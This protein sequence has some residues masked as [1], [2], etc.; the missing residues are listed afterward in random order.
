MRFRVGP[1]PKITRPNSFSKPGE[2][3]RLP[4]KEMPEPLARAL[5]QVRDDALRESI[6]RAASTSIGRRE[7]ST[8]EK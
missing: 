6:Q 1:M 7:H 5:A 8:R 4:L 2:A 3:P